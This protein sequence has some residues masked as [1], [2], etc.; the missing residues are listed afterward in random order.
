MVQIVVGKSCERRREEEWG[1]LLSLHRPTLL[2]LSLFP[3]IPDL[4]FLYQFF[5][6]N[7]FPWLP[8]V[9]T[10]GISL[11]LDKVIRL[12]PSSH[13]FH[14]NDLLHFVFL[15]SVHQVRWWSGEVWS[16]QFRFL[17]WSDQICVKHVMNLPVFRDLHSVYCIR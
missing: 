5:R 17:V 10:R 15:F 3:C 6:M 11:P 7:V 14:V 8:G 9:V 16:M 12:A 4:E 2:W 13:L 1:C